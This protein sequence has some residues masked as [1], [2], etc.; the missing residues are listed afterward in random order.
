MVSPAE[1]I[2]TCSFQSYVKSTVC[3][4]ALQE[5]QLQKSPR[6]QPGYLSWSQYLRSKDCP[7]GKICATED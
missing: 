1:N 3:R 2:Y 4:W 5:L 7:L 6:P